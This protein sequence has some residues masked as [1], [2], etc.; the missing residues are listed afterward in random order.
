MNHKGFWELIDVVNQEA[1][2]WDQDSIL[3][4]TQERLLEL[5][6][7][8]I[9]GFHNYLKWY[10]DAADTPSLVAAAVV[11]ND[12]TSDDGFN[13]FRAWLV[14]QGQAVY[15]K[16]LKCADSLAELDIPQEDYYTQFEFYGYIGSYA[17]EVKSLLE[18]KSIQE[19]GTNE[20]FELKPK[21]KELVEHI[22]KYHCAY[23]D[24]F[25]DSKDPAIKSLYQLVNKQ[26]NPYNVYDAALA[27]PLSSQEMKEMQAELEFEK[28]PDWKR[29]WMP[30][31][32]KEVVPELYSKYREHA[33]T[34]GGV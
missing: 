14:S 15:R 29:R 27:H 22:L 2:P 21:G 4:T 5:P 11:I 24:P 13:D 33:Y 20:Y 17:Y 34:L 31:D 26:M 3:L 19:I 12:G 7:P 30:A 23:T 9:I 25:A 10:M 18:Q 28:S 6:L 16:A 1:E 8:E 32:L